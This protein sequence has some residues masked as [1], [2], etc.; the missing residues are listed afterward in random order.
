[1]YSSF[2]TQS[3]RTLAGTHARRLSG[4]RAAGVTTVNKPNWHAPQQANWGQTPLRLGSRLAVQS[5]R[6]GSDPKCLLLV[7]SQLGQIHTPRVGQ[8]VLVDFEHGDPDRPSIVGSGNQVAGRSNHIILDDTAGNIQAQLKS[9]HEHSQ[10]SLGHITRIEDNQGRK[11]FRGEGFELRTDGHGAIRSK[12]GML[13]TTEPRAKASS[14]ILDSGE[15]QSRLEQAKQQHQSNSDLAQS[16]NAHAK[17]ADQ[18]EVDKAIQAQNKDVKGA[19]TEEGKFPEFQAPHLVLASPAGIA[20]TTPK[21][22]HQASGEHHA[23][24]SAAHTSV[25]TGKSFLVAAKEAIRVFAYK[26]GIRLFA[27]RGKVELEAQSNEL[28]A[29]ALKKITATSTAG[30]VY[31]TAPK[32]VING[33]GSFTIWDKN[34]ITSGTSGA[35]T[36]YVGKVDS[37]PGKSMATVMPKFEKPKNKIELNYHWPD[38]EPVVGAPYLV[39]FDNGKEFKGKLDDKGHA[40]I[41]DPPEGDYEVWFGEDS[42]PPVFAET[43]EQLFSGKVLNAAAGKEEEKAIADIANQ[44]KRR[45]GAF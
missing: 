9:D 22:T 16:H 41:N 34:G 35:W 30:S 12:D 20:S 38:L 14:H 3:P 13:I 4:V 29:T 42:R 11:D 33:G 31:L 1:M 17:D 43:K 36:E 28:K 25:S 18:S 44:F 37:P 32:I 7:P 45:K 15:T 40:V 26:A 39:V 24:T 21:T 5:W 10:L 27:A 6:L 8:E 23:I 2:A 19:S